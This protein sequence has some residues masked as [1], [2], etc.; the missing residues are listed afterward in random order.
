MKEQNKTKRIAVNTIVLYF[1]MLLLMAVSL[2]TSRV[3]LS[4]L[5]FDDFGIYNVVGGFVAMFAIVCNALSGACSRYLNYEMGKGNPEKLNLVFSSAVTIHIGLALVIL[6]LAET[7]GL[8]FL[9]NKMVIP[10]DRMYAAGWC[11]QLSLLTFCSSLIVVPYRSA[12][13]AHEKMS[14]FA[15]ISII[16][17]IGKQIGRASC[18]ERV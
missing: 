6:V 18:R 2:Y 9:Y 4:T 13:I 8:W 12:I 1:R 11:F 3:V 16:E 5:G 7:L 17:G 14:A 15:Y 10:D